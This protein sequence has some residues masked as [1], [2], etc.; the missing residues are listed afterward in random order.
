MYASLPR[1]FDGE[2]PTCQTEYG[3]VAVVW[4]FPIG[5][6]EEKFIMAEGWQEFEKKLF[7]R[8]DIDPADWGR[9]SCC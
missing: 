8:F 3:P 2:F 4:L 6:S 9:L 1:M 5:P 7:R